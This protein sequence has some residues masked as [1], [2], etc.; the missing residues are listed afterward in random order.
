MKNRLNMKLSHT[1]FVEDDDNFVD[2]WR[3]TQ[4]KITSLN[5]IIIILLF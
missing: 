3:I 5:Y 1:A 4:W 2:S